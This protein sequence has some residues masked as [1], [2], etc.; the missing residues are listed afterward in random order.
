MTDFDGD[1]EMST[2]WNA[3][4]RHTNKAGTDTRNFI[5]I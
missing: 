1:Y 2:G 5:P 4:A 3:T